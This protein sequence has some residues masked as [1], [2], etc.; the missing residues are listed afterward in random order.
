VTGVVANDFTFQFG[1]NTLT[2][3]IGI[4]V[5]SEESAKK[6]GLEAHLELIHFPL[7]K[8]LLVTNPNLN[9]ACYLSQFHLS[10]ASARGNT[11]TIR[12]SIAFAS[13]SDSGWKG[14]IHVESQISCSCFLITDN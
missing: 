7:T 9:P 1:R 11:H 3:Y 10:A 5:K 8:T 12:Q 2:G 13:S 6:R 14:T 4:A